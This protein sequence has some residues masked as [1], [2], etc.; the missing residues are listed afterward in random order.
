MTA[1]ATATTTPARSAAVR[2][3]AA[4]L[5]RL[6]EGISA[7]RRLG[8]AVDE[9]EAVRR[10]ADQRLGFPSDLAVIA[11]VGGTGVGKSTLL[12]ALAGEPVSAASVRRP[13]TGRPIAWVPSSGGR[14][15]DELLDW[16][17]VG[18]VRRH[19]DPSLG[20][21]AILDLPDVDSIE[22]EHRERVEELLPRVDAV[23]WVTDPEKY[24]DA[25]LHDEFMTRWIP[26]LERQLVVLNKADRLGGGDVEAVRRDLERSVADDRRGSRPSRGPAVVA[27]AAGSGEAT[28]V[29][30]WIGDLV[31]AK[32]IVAGRIAASIQAALGD[33][34]AQAGVDPDDQAR[35][36]VDP[37]NRR[38]AIERA[39]AEVLRLVDV[40]ATERQAVAATR[41][42]AR[43]AG[44]GPV[45]W[46]RSRFDRVSGR[47]Q[48]LADPATFLGRW[49]ERGTL[50]PAIVALRGATQGPLEDAPPALRSALATTTD[51]P[52]LTT[53]LRAAV[54][55]A[56]GR[57]GAL[58]PPSSRIW[59]LLGVLQTV[60][61]AGIIVAAA[62]I[63]LIVLT[64]APVDT[65]VVPVLGQVPIPFVLLV[66]LLLLGFILAWLLAVHAG[67]L[68]RRW[69]QS[70]GAEVRRSVERAVADEAFA[71]LDRLEA[72]RRALWLAVRGARETCGRI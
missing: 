3:I 64:R 7:A 39:T 15:V 18:E 31:D 2:G 14:E 4:C 22:T 6:D 35:P 44:G 46:L 62:W 68:G 43:P 41:A 55:E 21:V 61:T 53:R 17:G 63:V 40:P 8:L 10:D 1:T 57:P 51:A 12:N 60:A 23:V 13:T 29:R 67:W 28:A 72:A 49:S 37:S 5:A 30:H 26:R 11:L 27:A 70:V 48:R 71:P 52:H 69:A 56:I 66:G 20:G 25:V 59:R 16:L 54:N 36:I 65:T 19:D 32:R 47:E 42:R 58:E 38:R 9:A 50:A 24:R 34:A 45:G 33:L